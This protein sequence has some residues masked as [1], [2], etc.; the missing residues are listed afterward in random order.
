MEKDQRKPQ[1]PGQPIGQGN[2]GQGNPGQGNP[3]QGN[4]GQAIRV[5]IIPVKAVGP[6]RTT[7]DKAIPAR[8]DSVPVRTLPD[9]GSLARAAA[10]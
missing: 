9:K 1:D 7:L 4:P 6:V 5:R 2:P 8:A 10:G 3:G